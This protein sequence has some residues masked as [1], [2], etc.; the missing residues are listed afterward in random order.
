MQ[1][2]S[3][4]F[5]FTSSIGRK[6]IMAVT[7]LVLLGFVVGHLLGNLQVFLGQEQFNAYAATL[8]GMPALIWVA[9]L[10]LLVIVALHIWAAVVLSLEN[11]AARPEA[12]RKPGNIRATYASR[13]MRMSG[14]I[15]AAF[16][17][18]HLLHFTAQVTHADYRTMVD[19]AGRHDAFGMVIAGFSS[20]LVSGFYILAMGLLAMHLSHGIASMLQTIGWRNSG[21]RQMIDSI[22]WLFAMMIFVGYIS[23]PLA[24]LFGYF[25]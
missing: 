24:V 11:R 15:L 13:T 1:S 4:S 9:R 23:I 18:F 25:N 5:L 19:S 6:I 3:G 20:I 2:Q 21:T 16:I 22:S 14:I 10:A 8:Q 12:Y 7:G 17:I